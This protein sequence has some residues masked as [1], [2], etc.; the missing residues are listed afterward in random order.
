MST[1]GGRWRGGNARTGLGWG[2]W[3]RRDAGEI[4]GWSGDGP[5]GPRRFHRVGDEGWTYRHRGERRAPCGQLLLREARV[6]GGGDGAGETG[7]CEGLGLRRGSLRRAS[8]RRGGIDARPWGGVRRTGMYGRASGAHSSAPAS[9]SRSYVACRAAA[10][11]DENEKTKR[12]RRPRKTDGS[13]SILEYSRQ[14]TTARRPNDDVTMGI[15]DQ[16]LKQQRLIRAP[17]RCRRTPPRTSRRSR[18]SPR[19]WRCRTRG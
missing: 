5:D 12:W 3:K 11:C 15:G 9:P 17:N 4:G 1:G 13:W 19:T 14:T 18:C 2:R 8:G 16:V 7:G 6:C 10:G